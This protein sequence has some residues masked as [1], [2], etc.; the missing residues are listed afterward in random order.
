[1]NYQALVLNTDNFTQRHKFV[2]SLFFILFFVIPTIGG[3]YLAGPNRFLVPRNDKKR[4]DKKRLWITLF[5]FYLA[6]FQAIALPP[7]KPIAPSRPHFCGEL[8]PTEQADVSQKL[9]MALSGGYGKHI[10]HLKHRVAPQWAVIEPIL[11]KH[12]IPNDFKY[13]PLIESDLKADAVSVKG[14]VGYWQFMDETAKELGLNIAPEADERKDLEKSTE[15]ACRYLKIL[16]RNLGSWTLVAAAYNGGVGMVQRKI[17]KNG[18]RDYYAMTLNEETGYYLYRILATKELFTNPLYANGLAD[19]MLAFDAEAYD[20]ERAQARRMGWLVDSEPELTSTPIEV[21]SPFAS[22]PQTVF[23]DSVLNALLVKKSTEPAFFAGDVEAKLTRAGKPKIGQSWAFEI[24]Q[25]A[26]IG[27]TILQPGDVLY[28]LVDDLDSRG[29]L[30]L[31]ATKAVL[32]ASHE[33][34]SMTLLAQNPATG[35]TGVALPKTIK[36]G[37]V[38][39]WK[40]Q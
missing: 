3:I 37:W 10:Q 27:E 11:A 1:M 28:A 17:A 15:A 26:Q 12:R 35:Q 13:L 24:T 20:R 22:Q 14:A 34:V 30:F 36:P 18:V 25:E 33:T 40:M 19:G 16:Y 2:L 29:T 38:V 39:Q 31:R 7:K 6:V 8:V 4:N 32:Q 9:A 21:A 5:V 23:V